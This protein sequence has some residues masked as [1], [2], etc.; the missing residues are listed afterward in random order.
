MAIRTQPFSL[1]KYHL[2]VKAISPLATQDDIFVTYKIVE[3]NER[4]FL[5]K[6]LWVAVFLFALMMVVW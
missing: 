1:R 2:P 4:Q 6:I 5:L 3:Q